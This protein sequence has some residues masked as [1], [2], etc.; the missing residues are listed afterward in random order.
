[1]IAQFELRHSHIIV[2]SSG[3]GLSARALVDVSG[4]DYFNTIDPSIT[5]T[6]AAS[7]TTT[8]GGR[9]CPRTRPQGKVNQLRACGTQLSIVKHWFNPGGR[10]YGRHVPQVRVPEQLLSDNGLG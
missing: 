3:V 9:T 7:L 6:I 5:T 2:L 10:R 4:V 1:M 8:T